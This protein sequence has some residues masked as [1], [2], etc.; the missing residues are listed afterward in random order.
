VGFVSTNR[1]PLQEPQGEIMIVSFV[2]ALPDKQVEKA[3]D[4]MQ[5]MPRSVRKTLRL[6]K[7]RQRNVNTHD[8]VDDYLAMDCRVDT[9]HTQN[10]EFLDREYGFDEF[11]DI[12]DEHEGLTITSAM[13]EV[14]A[15]EYLTGYNII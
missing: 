2:T 10:L 14:E 7:P 13:S 11:G 6:T 8:G 9:Y 4:W 12:D 1:C 15:F 3:T 5:A